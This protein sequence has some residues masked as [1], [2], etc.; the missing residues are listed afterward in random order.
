M[1][2]FVFGIMLK[3]KTRYTNKQVF[4][5]LYDTCK[6]VIESNDVEKGEGEGVIFA[7]FLLQDCNKK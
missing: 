7:P 1:V 4:N 5:K 2:I 3:I 6:F